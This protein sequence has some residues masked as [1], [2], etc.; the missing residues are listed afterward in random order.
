[1]WSSQT[2]TTASGLRRQASAS[3]TQ[4]YL[5]AF[6]TLVGGA[7]KYGAAMQFPG[8]INRPGTGGFGGDY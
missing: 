7:A 5:N 1:M 8:M 2:A 3:R 6:G 4:G